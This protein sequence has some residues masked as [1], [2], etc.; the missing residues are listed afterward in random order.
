M[1]L[2]DIL[3]KVALRRDSLWRQN[4]GLKH[5]VEELLVDQKEN[6]PILLERAKANLTAKGCRVLVASTPEEALKHILSLAGQSPV[7]QAYSPIL[8]GLG[9]PG[10]LRQAGV[11]V[12]ETHFGALAVDLLNQLPAHPD[13][14]AG[15]LTEEEILKSLA[16]YAGTSGVMGKREILK[17]VRQ[18]LRPEIEAA[19]LGI[20]GVSA[21]IAEH[22]SLVLGEDQGHMRA[23]SNLPPVHLTVVSPRQ[24]VPSL[25]D[26]VRYL[27][28][29]AIESYGRNVQTYLSVIS[30]PS[31]TADIEFKMVNG[32]HGP[33]ELYVLFLLYA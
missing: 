11:R 3:E 8:Q 9:L 29:Q 20:S 24:I 27:R 5:Q 15:D 31:R 1:A 23:V 19:P 7:V 2:A 12:T 30:G 25:D 33:G 22:G 13:F 4:P 32:V 10:K 6:L 14:P 26:A 16:S 21:V 17:A 28:Y 18:Q